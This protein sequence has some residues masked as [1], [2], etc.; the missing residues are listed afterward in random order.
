ME[1]KR[2]KDKTILIFKHDNRQSNPPSEI[3][4]H[5]PALAVSVALDNPPVTE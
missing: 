4:Y 1:G 5:T 3:P 2:E